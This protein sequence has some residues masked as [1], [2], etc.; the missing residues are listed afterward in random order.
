MNRTELKENIKRLKEKYLPIR[1]AALLE[2]KKDTEAFLLKIEDMDEE[3][4]ARR[5]EKTQLSREQKKRLADAYLLKNFSMHD[6]VTEFGFDL[7]SVCG[8]MRGLEYEEIRY[9]AFD[10]NDRYLGLCRG[11][12]KRSGGIHSRIVRPVLGEL[13]KDYPECCC[14]ISVHNH[15]KCAAAYPSTNDGIAAFRMKEALRMCGIRLYDDCIFSVFDFYSRRQYE[16]D[17]KDA[18][19]KILSG[20]GLSEETLARIEKENRLL[21]KALRDQ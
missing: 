8:D 4:I 13:L 11:S 9:L 21:A 14:V 2:Q 6:T 20:P 15:D 17:K 18:E 16:R 5:L 12:G 3:E 7:E 10:K 19:G 1:E